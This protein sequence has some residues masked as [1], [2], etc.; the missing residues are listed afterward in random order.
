MQSHA[1]IIRD[2]N[3]ECVVSKPSENLDN[4]DHW[5]YLHFPLQWMW[6][7]SI[8]YDELSYRNS[9]IDIKE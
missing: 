5:C 1:V 8:K 9:N 3:V 4:E 2:P 7:C 6:C